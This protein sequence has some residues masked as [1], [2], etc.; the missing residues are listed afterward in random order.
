MSTGNHIVVL[1][2]GVCNLCNGAVQFIIKRDPSFVFK[3]ASL[4]S[5]F[6]QSHLKKLNLPL[7]ALHSFI[8]LESGIYYQQSD[9]ALKIAANLK[10]PWSAL[11]IFKVIPKFIRDSLYTFIASNRYRFFGKRNSC[12]IPTPE[13]QARFIQ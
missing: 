10:G 2:D 8:V 1:F 3:F 13:L 4:Q 9:A 7:Q 12:M 5:E 11:S 6:G